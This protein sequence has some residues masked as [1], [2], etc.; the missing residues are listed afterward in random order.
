MYTVSLPDCIV[1]FFS[2]V[3]QVGWREV[4][5]AFKSAMLWV[6]NILCLTRYI[7]PLVL[8]N[9]RRKNQQYTLD[10]DGSVLYRPSL[11]ERF[12]SVFRSGIYT[13]LIM[14]LL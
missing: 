4:R 3:V 9:R 11:W 10:S 14:K 1:C 12:T 5:Q 2:P 13:I 8:I 6:W 7:N